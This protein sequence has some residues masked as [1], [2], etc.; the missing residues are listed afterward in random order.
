MNFDRQ[1]QDLLNQMDATYKE[2]MK[3]RDRLEELFREAEDTFEIANEAVYTV[4][5]ALFALQAL[6]TRLR[7]VDIVSILP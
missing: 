1:N 5:E 7:E 2:L 3:N 6:D 4:R